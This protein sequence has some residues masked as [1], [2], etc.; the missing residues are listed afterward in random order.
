MRGADELRWEPLPS[1]SRG[2][3]EGSD[4]RLGDFLED[5]L[6]SIQHSVRPRT[7]RR[8]AEYV[9]LHIKPTLGTVTLSSLEARDLQHLYS[10]R[11]RAGLSPTSILHLHRALHR[12]LSQAQL[13]GLVDVN[14]TTLVHPPKYDGIEVQA[15]SPEEADGFLNAARG[16]RLETLYV[17]AITTGMRQGELLGLRW[18]DIDLERRS[19]RVTGSLQYIP[20][21]GLVRSQP[22]T[23]KSRRQVLLTH[24]GVKSLRHHRLQQDTQRSRSG[25]R[26]RE[27]DFVFTSKD[28]HPLYATNVINRSLP[29]ILR[30]AGLRKIRFHDLRHTTATLLLGQGVHPKIVSEMLG[31]SNVGITLDLYSHATPTMQE[32]A[33]SALDA[34][35][36]EPRN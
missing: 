19:I 25:E 11:M 9:R 12:A 17:L 5:W 29:R 7:W 1:P 23:R 21:Q 6:T 14:V 30:S 33:T 13:W 34:I 22:K 20:G 24:L 35:L 27:L 26:W 31:H 8:Y 4:E 2:A 16:D 28:G 3:H 36:G 15:L 32:V 10:G 18:R